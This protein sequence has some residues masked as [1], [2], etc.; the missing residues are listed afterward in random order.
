MKYLKQFGIILALSFAG[1]VLHA[2]IPLP[3]P[4]SIY[5]I[6]ILF[7][8]LERGILNLSDLRETVMF[9]IQIMPV[10]FIPAAAG[11]IQSWSLVKNALLPYF[12]ITVPVTFLVMM[13]AGWTTQFVIRRRHKH[14]ADRQY[15]KEGTKEDE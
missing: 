10:L 2:L 5:G 14:K 3:V 1:E 9:L 7:G 12:L 11:L 8:L 6:I 4:A 13:A 15:E